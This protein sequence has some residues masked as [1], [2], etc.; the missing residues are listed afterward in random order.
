MW[1][2]LESKDINLFC[3]LKMRLR[4]YIQDLGALI[5][6]K[7]SKKVILDSSHLKISV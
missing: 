5:G 3:V 1:V 2:G 6:Y 7:I 4:L